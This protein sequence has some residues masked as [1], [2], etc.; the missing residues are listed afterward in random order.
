MCAYVHV[1]VC[2]QYVSVYVCVRVSVCMCGLVCLSAIYLLIYQGIPITQCNWNSKVSDRELIF[3]HSVN[4]YVVTE[5][6]LNL[7]EN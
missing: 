2:V 6:S 4:S 1:C 3:A 7:K 5:T